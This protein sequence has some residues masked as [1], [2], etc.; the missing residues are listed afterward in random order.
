MMRYI[1]FI[2]VLES[3]FGSN[4]LLSQQLPLFTQYRESQGII[5]PAALSSSYLMYGHQK[6]FGISHRAQWMD[7]EVSGTPTTQYIRYEHFWKKKG[8]LW[9][10]YLMNDN[11]G[12]L[13]LTGWYGKIGG[14]I[15]PGYNSDFGFAGGLNFGVVQY[16]FKSDGS[17]IRDSGDP[18]LAAS[19]QNTW[20][21]DV[22]GGLFAFYE[23]RQSGQI[24]AGFSIPQIVGG[25][26][27]FTDSLYLLRHPHLYL[28]GGYIHNLNRDGNVLEFSTWAKYVCNAP[29]NIDVNVRFLVEGFFWIGVGWNTSS[30]SHLEF[31]LVLGE[32]RNLKIGGSW[33]T[34][35]GELEDFG[36]SFEINIS[37]A[38]GGSIYDY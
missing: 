31:G 4:V 30:T 33:G 19:S 24:Y 9:G 18:I 14:V 7:S 37:R 36:H 25:K 29:V 3:V 26:V 34:S 35:W 22:G 1:L 20:Y 32:D 15:T 28:N 10:S 21:P 2:I 23:T 17:R 27:P 13:G 8:L 16:R 11:A 6:Y 5:N 38:W 12:K